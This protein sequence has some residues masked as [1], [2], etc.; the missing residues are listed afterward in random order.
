MY[1]Y[2]QGHWWSDRVD[3]P[4]EYLQRERLGGIALK[5]NQT[6]PG[7][8]VSWRFADPE[9]AVKVAILV[10][11]A[12]PDRFTVV[13]YNTTGTEQRADMGTWNVV[14]GIWEMSQG[15][16]PQGGD[17]AQNNVSTR[18]VEIERSGSLPVSFA[19]GATTVMTFRLK[20]KAGVQPE[21]RPDLGI[22]DDDVIRKGSRLS[23]TVHSL[24]SV[25]APGG[26]LT[27]E[28]PEGKVL[29]STP[30]PALAAPS[31]LRAK[32]AT[33]TLT[34]PA[35]APNLLHVKVSTGAPEVTQR[36]NL[37]ILGKAN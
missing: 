37:V 12:T 13:A 4:N 32:T 19:P 26:T 34:V 6:Y 27:L 25:A 10:R 1:M 14:G 28:T 23:V 30:V 11:D 16:A 15:I 33:V 5:R 29:A 2:T 36:N 17:V 22:G 3:A 20:Q 21:H 35:G 7:N 8:A 18:E 31:D 9:A 24:G